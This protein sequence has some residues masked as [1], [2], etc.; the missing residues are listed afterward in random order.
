MKITFIVILVTM[1]ILANTHNQ[2]DRP[3]E[4]TSISLS[5]AQA[6][7]SAKI[8]YVLTQLQLGPVE[9]TDIIGQ[10]SAAIKV[11]RFVAMSNTYDESIMT[12]KDKYYEDG[13]TMVAYDLYQALIH[14]KGVCTSN[15]LEVAALLKP[16]GVIAFCLHAESTEGGD[17]MANIV[18]IGGSYYY[19]D[20]TLE[21]YCHDESGEDPQYQQLFCAGLGR[22]SYERLY[23]PRHVLNEQ[24]CLPDFPLHIDSADI[25]RLIVNKLVTND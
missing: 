2:A 18:L 14:Q 11:H 6:V 1:L 9:P 20:A 3:Q 22:E 24:Y 15:A 7:I 10:L 16:I 12:G 21:R 19:F 13:E 17:Y 23:L 4:F 5:E 8:N 25:P